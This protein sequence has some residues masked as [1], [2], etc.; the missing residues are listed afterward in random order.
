MR[1]HFTPTRMAK[2][3]RKT[4]TSVIVDMEKLEPSYTANDAV[5]LAAFQ[6][7]KHI[8]SPCKPEI[9][10]VGSLAKLIHGII[11][12]PWHSLCLTKCPAGI[13]D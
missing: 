8:E 6:N 1:Y 4:I 13:S 3:E 9:P 11:L 10:L 2:I 7:V 12:L 5:T